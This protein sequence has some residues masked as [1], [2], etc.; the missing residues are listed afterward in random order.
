MPPFDYSKELAPV[1]TAVLL[2]RMSDLKQLVNDGSDINAQ[3]ELGRS[4]LIAVIDQDFA[5]PEWT[6]FLIASGIDINLKDKD[7]D[8]ALDI[9]KYREHKEA[10][11]LLCKLN[12]I[13]H[14][15]PSA[16]ERRWDLIYEAFDA[17]DKIK[18]GTQ[19][20]KSNSSK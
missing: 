8:T 14:D 11:E 5:N 1:V 3:D 4:A 18:N 6:D 9:A 15:G 17:A 19:D 7:G 10:I 20:G 2:E 16:K 13:G 12:A